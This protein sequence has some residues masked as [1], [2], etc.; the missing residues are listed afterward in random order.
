[1]PETHIDILA[2]PQCMVRDRFDDAEID[3]GA[4]ERAGVVTDIREVFGFAKPREVIETDEELLVFEGGRYQDGDSPSYIDYLEVGPAHVEVEIRAETPLAAAV[5][6]EVYTVLDD[7][8]LFQSLRDAERQ[9]DY[10]TRIRVQLPFLAHRLLS[11]EVERFLT[12]FGG[13]FSDDLH[14]VEVH[15]VIMA[16]NFYRKPDLERIQE[17]DLPSYRLRSELTDSTK[18][19]FLRIKS[20]KDFAEGIFQVSIDDSFD[21]AEEFMEGLSTTIASGQD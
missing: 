16:I 17:A 14:T 6:E 12:E 1:M 15:P 13:A 9:R 8:N 3:I 21:A 20:P 19:A 11:P 2:P 18:G 7:A 10:R 4:I 5:L